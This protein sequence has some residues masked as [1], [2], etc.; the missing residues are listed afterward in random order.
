ME[1]VAPG[2]AAELYDTAAVIA[3][4]VDDASRALDV[5]VVPYTDGSVGGGEPRLWNGLVGVTTP[6]PF[7]LSGGIVITGLLATGPLEPDPGHV[8]PIRSGAALPLGLGPRRIGLV[9]DSPE[10]SLTTS[11]GGGGVFLRPTGES[12]DASAGAALRQGK[13]RRTTR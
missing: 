8:R 12:G 11:S 7:S 6:G 3:Q 10:P 13:P 5:G 2:R 9:V 4:T 1:R